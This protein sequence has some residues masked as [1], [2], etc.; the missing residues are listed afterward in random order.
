LLA[1]AVVVNMLQVV[2]VVVV[3]GHQYLESPLVVV[4]QPNL[5]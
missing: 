3:I 1:V 5:L 4:G 2:V